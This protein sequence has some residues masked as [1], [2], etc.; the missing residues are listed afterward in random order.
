[1]TTH[2]EFTEKRKQR[3]VTPERARLAAQRLI[4]SHFRNPGREHARVTIPVNLDDDD[5]VIMDFISQ[6]ER[7]GGH[8]T[9]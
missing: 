4:D 9:K 3:I 7:D 6:A 8:S 1:M 2:E 5:V